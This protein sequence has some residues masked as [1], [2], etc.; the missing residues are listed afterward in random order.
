M[1]LSNHTEYKFDNPPPT[2][3]TKK[4]EGEGRATNHKTYTT[5]FH[6]IF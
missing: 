5:F 2:A 1:P 3:K 4:Y 6:E